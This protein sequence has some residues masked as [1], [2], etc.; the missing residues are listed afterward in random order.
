MWISDVSPG[1]LFK[2]NGKKSNEKADETRSFETFRV[3]L[4]DMVTNVLRLRLIQK[5]TRL[6]QK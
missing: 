6:G 2:R 5:E 4:F 3:T 1:N